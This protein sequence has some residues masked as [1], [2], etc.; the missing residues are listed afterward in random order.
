VSETASG[1]F[2][3]RLSLLDEKMTLVI[4]GWTVGTVCIGTLV[5]SALSLANAAPIG[6]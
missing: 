3:R 6:F 2:A 5:L 1:G 4:L